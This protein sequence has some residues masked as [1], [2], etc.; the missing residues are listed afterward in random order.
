MPLTGIAL[1]GRWPFRLR[2]HGVAVQAFKAVE[3]AE[4]LARL[5]SLHGDA[6]DGAMADGGTRARRQVAYPLQAKRDAFI[7]EYHRRPFDPDQ[8]GPCRGKWGLV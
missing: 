4:V 7:A 8:C 6:A 5:M 3:M 1:V 2:D